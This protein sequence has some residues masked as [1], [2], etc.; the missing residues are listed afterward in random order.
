MDWTEVVLYGRS[1]YWA[2]VIEHAVERLLTDVYLPKN[3][4]GKNWMIYGYFFSRVNGASEMS[5]N[6]TGFGTKRKSKR[7][8]SGVLSEERHK[9]RASQGCFSMLSFPFVR[10]HFAEPLPPPP[11]P[12][13]IH[14]CSH[15]RTQPCHP[16]PRR[17][18]HERARII[19]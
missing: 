7:V 10:I 13:C 19:P 4:A 1:G 17:R 8:T 18:K 6:T 5:A 3:E 9:D 11:A 2:W 15:Y 12:P 16:S 14:R